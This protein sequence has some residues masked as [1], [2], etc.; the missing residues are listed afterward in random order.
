MS[1][2]LL[3]QS[4]RDNMENLREEFDRSDIIRDMIDK[5]RGIVVDE[6]NNGGVC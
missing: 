3:Y 5:I 4:L 1:Y 6:S 2:H